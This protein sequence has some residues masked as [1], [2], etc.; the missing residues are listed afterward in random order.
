MKL[1]ALL[2]VPLFVVRVFF[3]EL[4]G[5]GVLYAVGHFVVK[6]W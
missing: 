2:L 6:Y 3:W 1:L 4:V 5:C